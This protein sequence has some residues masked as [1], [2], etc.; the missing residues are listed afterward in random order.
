MRKSEPYEE[1][2]YTPHEGLVDLLKNQL[3]EKLATKMGQDPVKVSKKEKG[4]MNRMKFYYLDKHIFQAMA[5]LTFFFEAI[6]KHPEL[7]ELYEDDIKDLLGVRRD[8]ADKH[9]CGF[10]FLNLLRSILKVGD[11]HLERVNDIQ[12]EEEIERDF[13]RILIHDA[14]RI[15]RNKVSSLLA[16]GYKKE[17]GKVMLVDFRKENIRNVILDDFKRALAWTGALASNLDP[18]SVDDEPQRTFDFDSEKLLK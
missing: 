16:G 18:G 15:V 13:R 2:Y 14:M 1:K 11:L 10:M 12:T 7:E 9:V 3:H 4:K 8:K 6:A 5:N 17:N